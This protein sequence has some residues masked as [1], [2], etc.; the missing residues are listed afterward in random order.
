MC[1]YFRPGQTLA[2]LPG[3]TPSFLHGA[4]KRSWGVEPGNEAIQIPNCSYH[5][6]DVSQ[7]TVETLNEFHSPTVSL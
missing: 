7:S 1:S 3:F 4:I 2:S 6:S 5:S